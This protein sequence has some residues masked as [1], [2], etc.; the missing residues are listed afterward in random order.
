MRVDY[1]VSCHQKP[2]NPARS[3]KWDEALQGKIKLDKLES[4]IRI[5]TLHFE[6]HWVKQPGQLKKF[7]F[8]TLL[9]PPTKNGTNWTKDGTTIQISEGNEVFCI[10][11]IVC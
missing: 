10:S 7:A 6:R 11:I 9:T 3:K 5:C 8:P 4:F 1:K 2:K